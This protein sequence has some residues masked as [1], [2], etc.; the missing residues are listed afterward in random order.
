MQIYKKEFIGREINFVEN[1][2]VLLTI[3]EFHREKEMSKSC[4]IAEFSS[5]NVIARNMFT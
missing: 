1:M 2:E 4:I 5:L 3:D